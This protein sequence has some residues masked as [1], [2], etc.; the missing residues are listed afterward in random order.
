MPKKVWGDFWTP[1]EEDDQPI[2]A[3]VDMDY[4]TFRYRHVIDQ[5]AFDA[6]IAH[7]LADIESWAAQSE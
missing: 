4:D 7:E 3:D 5:T 1:P 6:W 2:P